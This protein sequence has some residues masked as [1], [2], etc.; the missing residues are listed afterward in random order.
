[1]LYLFSGTPR[2][3][4]MATCLQQLAGAW[5]LNLKTECVDVKRSAKHDLSLAKV[6]KA[7]WTGS[8]LRSSTQCFCR[9]RALASPERLGLIFEAPDRFAAMTPRGVSNS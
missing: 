6:A 5:T 3:L 1:M 9:R 8:P 4:D 7:T 2:R